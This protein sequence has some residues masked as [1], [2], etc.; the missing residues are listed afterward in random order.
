M[1]EANSIHAH[2]FAQDTHM[3]LY[4]HFQFRTYLLNISTFFFPNSLSLTPSL[5]PISS[6]LDISI[7]PK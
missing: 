7:R 1:P 4:V 2:H 5:H 3:S 6:S